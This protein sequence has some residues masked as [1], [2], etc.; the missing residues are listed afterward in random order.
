MKRLLLIPLLL[1]LASCATGTTPPTTCY[2]NAA[3]AEAS[4]S[5]AYDRLYAAVVSEMISRESA[6]EALEWLGLAN[7]LLDDAT[8]MC[9]KDELLS[10]DYVVQALKALNEA[11]LF[12]G[13]E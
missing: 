3:I 2:Q 5:T 6:I 7:I 12:I 1:I 11:L 9:S 13:G 4:I 8:N 10:G